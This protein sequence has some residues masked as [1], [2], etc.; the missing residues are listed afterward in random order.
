MENIVV[1]CFENWECKSFSSKVECFG[2]KNVYGTKKKSN[3]K[4][5]KK[6]KPTESYTQTP[7]NVKVKE[8]KQNIIV[9]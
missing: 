9:L 7:G 4:K 3:S 2:R 6:I 8:K 1:F 5:K